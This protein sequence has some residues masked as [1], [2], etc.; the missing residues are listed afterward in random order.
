[1]TGENWIRRK[2]EMNSEGQYTYGSRFSVRLHG[3][4]WPAAGATAALA[5]ALWLLA[6]TRSVVF[7]TSLGSSTIF[8]FAFTEAEAAQPRALFGGHIGAALIGVFCYHLFGDTI[9][10]YVMAVVLTMIYMIFTRT[11]HPPAGANPLLMISCHADLLVVVKII[12][13]GVMALFFMT[14]LWSIIRPGKTYPVKWW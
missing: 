8:L 6:D 11:I 7:F 12:I 10:V 2:A 4:F 5:F 1:M 13:P 9:W 3:I 14:W